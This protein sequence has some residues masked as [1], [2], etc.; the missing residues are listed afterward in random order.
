[1]QSLENSFSKCMHEP[2]TSVWLSK[3]IIIGIF[4]LF[5]AVARSLVSLSKG[6]IKSPFDFFS[7][8][9]VS[10]FAGVMWSLFTARL[11]ADDL[12]ILG[13]IAG[14][15]SYMSVQG[16][17]FIVAKIVQNKFKIEIEKEK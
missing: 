13:F 1:M 17:S 10:G 8:V 4:S 14:M 5:G 6:E 11:Y 15:G 3:W 16:L 7:L 9:I 12:A 2:I